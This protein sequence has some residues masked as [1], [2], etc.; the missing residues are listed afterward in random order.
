MFVPLLTSTRVT[1]LVEKNPFRFGSKLT[2]FRASVLA[3]NRSPLPGCTASPR[4]TAPSREKYRLIVMVATSISATS[5]SGMVYLITEGAQAGS[6]AS[7]I[8][9]TFGGLLVLGDCSGALV[10][11]TSVVRFPERAKAA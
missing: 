8:K 5:L 4:F 9:P 7:T 11:E 1:R 10:K 2:R 3:T 6:V